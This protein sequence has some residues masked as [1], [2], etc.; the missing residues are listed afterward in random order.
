MKFMLFMTTL[1]P[2]LHDALFH[3][4]KKH[5]RVPNNNDFTIYDVI[6]LEIQASAKTWNLLY[7]KK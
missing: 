4:L 6:E 3:P 7:V 2:G 1:T 5:F